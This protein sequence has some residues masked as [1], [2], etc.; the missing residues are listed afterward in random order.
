MERTLQPASTKA[1][2]QN[3]NQ[4]STIVP[5]NAQFL[6]PADSS[7]QERQ[8]RTLKQGDTFAV[9]GHNGDVISGPRSPEGIYHQD[10]R[11][12]SHLYLTIEGVRPML[13]SSTVRDDNATMTCDLTNPD[14]HGQDGALILEHDLIHI[15]R[16][17]FLWRASCFE[18]L[19][20]RNF[21]ALPRRVNLEISFRADFADLFEVRGA[22]RRERGTHHPSETQQSN[23]TLAYSGLDGQRR[24]THLR[25]YPRP[26]SLSS[27]IALFEL[28][29]A[30]G[31]R[32]IIFLEICCGS[33]RSISTLPRDFFIALRD[34]RREIRTSVSRA[35]SV[36]TSNDIFN[37]AVRRSVS[38][39]Y[40][41]VTNT[42]E[43]PYPYAGIPWFSAIFGRDALITALMTLW[44]DPT[45]A[46]GVLNHLA[47]NQ[48]TDFDPF[49]DAEP[50]KILHEVR[51]WGNG[52]HWRSAVP[53]ATTAVSTQ[54]RCSW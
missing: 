46:R 41:L 51:A 4:Q 34:A 9:F 19:S 20:I 30:P 3:Q 27:G 2:T 1:R 39:L 36:A 33:K 10:T 48:A 13:L 15:R 16:S 7:L 29:L 5:A 8:P 26:H 6:V 12:L 42:P 11:Y 44:L 37:E 32:C 24:E 18:H 25:F 23:V 50:G 22:Q 47:A 54:P 45:I 38:D 49:A 21:D 40:L 14:L 31:E 35:A 28:D 53:A 52:Q 17:R 43:G